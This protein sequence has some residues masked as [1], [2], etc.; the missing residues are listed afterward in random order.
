VPTAST[1]RDPIAEDEELFRAL[2]GADIEGALILPSAIDLQGTSV[3]RARYLSSPSETFAHVSEGF[4]GLAVVTVRSLP[5]PVA[6]PHEPAIVWEFFV[7]DDPFRDSRG[8]EHAAHAEIRVR[9]SDRNRALNARPKGAMRQL[10]R[11]ALAAALRL[12]TPP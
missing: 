7:I 5:G 1:P 10:L 6:N 12:H 4:T 3:H 9:R 8:V 11:H 2:R